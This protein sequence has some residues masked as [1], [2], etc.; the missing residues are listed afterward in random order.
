M[1]YCEVRSLDHSKCL[2]PFNSPGKN[3]LGSFSGFQPTPAREFMSDLGDDL[4]FVPEQFSGLAKLFPLPNLVLFPHVMQPLHVFEPRYVDLLHQALEG[5]RLIAM[6]LLEGNWERD[7]EGRPPVAPVACVGR[8]ITWQAQGD[9][10]YNVLLLGLARARIARELPPDRTF[11]EAEVEILADEYP[12]ANGAARGILHRRLVK[13]FQEMM[14]QIRDAEELFNQ[15]SVDSLSLGTLTDVISFA[16][17]LTVRAKQALLAETNVDRRAN[18]L[19]GHLK[20]AASD[21]FAHSLTA[22]FPP[23]FSSN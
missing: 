17:D 5:D 21:T 3:V 10:R 11:R 15:L 4:T 2:V 18:M 23:A 14:P 16:L 7:Y 6:A 19:L 22:G 9:S 8:V 1:L 13:A 12:K 20:I